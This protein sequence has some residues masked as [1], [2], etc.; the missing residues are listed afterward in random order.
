MD[1]EQRLCGVIIAG[2]VA[3]LERPGG[4]DA[5]GMDDLTEI[6]LAQAE[7]R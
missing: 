3:V 1:S 2:E 7:E 4:R 5:A 6:T